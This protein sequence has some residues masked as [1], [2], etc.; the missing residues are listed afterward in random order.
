MQAFDTLSYRGQLHRLRRLALA[1]LDH[2][3]I[4]ASRLVPLRHET[5]TTFRVFAAD[6]QQYVLRIHRPHGHPIAHIRSEVRW[7]MALRQETDVAVPEPVR[8]RDGALLTM[9]DAPGIPAARAC[10]LFRWL[11]GRF[12]DDHLRPCQMERIG[13]VMAQLHAHAAHWQPPSD[14]VRGRVDGLTEQVRRT[15]WAPPATASPD[16]ALH[17]TDDDVARTVALVTTLCSSQDAAVVAQTIAHIRTVFQQL[18]AG[19]DV[20]GLIH[21]DLHQENY[22]FHHGTPRVIDFDDCGWGH[23][24]FDLSVTL[25]EVQHLPTYPALR[26]ALLAGYR[27]I[28]PFARTH[29]GYLATF[30]ALRRLQLLMWVLESR[31]HPAFRADWAA[32]ARYD[33]QQLEH[34]VARADH[35]TQTPR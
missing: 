19:Q 33:V 13:V 29:E 31:D 26:A 4:P 34:F 12:F 3:A 15:A 10:V 14:F 5:N 20:F 25:R 16:P 27:T 30:F 6:T 8:T 2:Y 22:C 17:P 21:A 24:M 1:A 35:L 32:R 18:G 11:P 7:L 23:Y 28:R 9:A